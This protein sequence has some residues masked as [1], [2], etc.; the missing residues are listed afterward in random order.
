MQLLNIPIDK[1]NI[2]GGSIALGHPIAMT[3]AKII[4][5]LLSTFK[6]K[7]GK[8]GLAATCN[9]DGGSTAMII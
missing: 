7:G 3:G 1:V 4:Q 5:S 6:I 9:A 2:N 8:Y